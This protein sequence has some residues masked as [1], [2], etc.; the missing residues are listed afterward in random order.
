MSTTTGFGRDA[1][2][3]PIE[4]RRSLDD[5]SVPEEVDVNVR[6]GGVGEGEEEEMSEK[7][8]LDGGVCAFEERACDGS[9]LRPEDPDCTVPEGWT[10]NLTTG[11]DFT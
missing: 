4:P 8:E 3:I 11:R 9:A 7:I 10:N 6:R 2:G 1:I 5:F